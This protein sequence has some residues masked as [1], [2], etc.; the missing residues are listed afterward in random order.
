[1]GVSASPQNMAFAM[2]SDGLPTTFVPERNLLFLTL[3]DTLVIDVCE[4]DYSGY[5]ACRGNTIKVMPLVL[6]LGL[7]RPLFIRMPQSRHN[8]KTRQLQ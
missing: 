6:T 4:T 3:A 1:V 2:Q 8:S 7:A 5:P